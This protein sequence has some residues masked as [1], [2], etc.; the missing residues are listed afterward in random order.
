MHSL[1]LSEA[2]YSNLADFRYR[3]RQFL[4]FSEQAARS[5]KLE[6]QHHQLLLALRAQPDTHAV[7]GALA[8]RLQIQHNTA[9]ELVDRLARRGLVRRSRA[10]D[11]RRCVLVEIT[12][13]G[14]ATLE[15]LSQT[16]LDELRR[17]GPSLVRS[18]NAVIRRSH[19][20]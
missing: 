10:A 2:D 11:D 19:A 13:R 12:A 6:P 18:L 4:H 14:N 5:V 16:H 20:K 3:I 17:A 15:K 9:V 7:I 1:S 8:E